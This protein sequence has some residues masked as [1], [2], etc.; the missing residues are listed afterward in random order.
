VHQ[1][2]SS[3]E[4]QNVVGAAA[5]ALSTAAALEFRN[6][7]ATTRTSKKQSMTEN[8][9]RY[10]N[11]LDAYGSGE[12]LEDLQKAVGIYEVESSTSSSS[13]SSS[14]SS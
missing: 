7:Q 6:Q 14:S 8:E 12:S 11:L 1:Y 2:Q 9:K 4:G 3:A 10:Q 13:S 5:V